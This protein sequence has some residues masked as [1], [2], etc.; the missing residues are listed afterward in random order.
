M[1]YRRQAFNAAETIAQPVLNIV[2][3][4]N[5]EFQKLE[6]ESSKPETRG[7][8]FETLYELPDRYKEGDLYYGAAGVFGGQAGLYIRDGNGWRKL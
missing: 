2:R 5:G 4:L 6:I 1:T 7:I 3:W 8:Q